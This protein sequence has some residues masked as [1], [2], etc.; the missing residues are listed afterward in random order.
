MPLRWKQS[1]VWAKIA[2]QK[3]KGISDQNWK[4]SFAGVQAAMTS[5]GLNLETTESEF[6]KLSAPKDKKG[7]VKHS[8]RRITVSRLQNTITTCIEN[9]LTGNT[10]LLSET[11]MLAVHKN[12][13]ELFPSSAAKGTATANHAESDAINELHALLGIECCLQAFHLWEN[14]VADVALCLKGQDLENEVFLADQGKHGVVGVKG[15]VNFCHSGHI[16][17]I[18]DMVNILQRDMSLTCIGKNK[19]NNIEVVWFFHGQDTMRALQDV[20][21][22]K[23]TFR[24]VLQPKKRSPHIF[25]QFYSQSKFQFNVGTSQDE[26]QRLL[27]AK[28]AAVQT[29]RLRALTFLNEDDSQI[30]SETHRTEHASF[31]LT[32]AA[33]AKL[34]VHVDRYPDDAYG[35]VDFRVQIKARIQDKTV[36][37]IWHM[38]REGSHPY[39]PDEIDILQITHIAFKT[40]YALPMR[41]VED[42]AILSYLTEE[43]LMVGSVAFNQKWQQRHVRYR[44]DMSNDSDVRRY[45]AH[46]TAASGIPKMTDQHFYSDLLTSNALKFGSKKQIKE[47]KAQANADAQT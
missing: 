32:R 31:C 4:Q 45:I 24:P 40:V 43:E 9:L 42:G 17:T 47:R 13:V 6:C 39:N 30:D 15:V 3:P 41:K 37:T 29:G 8:R 14:R 44:Y 16:I 34:G 27:N 21:N 35:P 20:G 1:D 11:E 2:N 38:R 26:R 33:C 36:D 19:S 22:D 28:I 5:L 23:L 25:T 10:R 12:R 7:H 18:Q 46:C